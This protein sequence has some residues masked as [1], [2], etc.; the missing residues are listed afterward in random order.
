VTIALLVSVGTVFAF[1]SLPSSFYGIVKYNGENL[2]E[3]TLVEAM[4][5]NEV[6]AK[7]YSEMYQGDSVYTLDVRGDDTDTTE[8]DGGKE[9]DTIYFRVGGLM[10]SQTAEWHAGTNV[11]LDLTVDSTSALNSPQSTPTA[12]ATQTP[13]G[14]I[15]ETGGKA[16]SSNA[17]IRNRRV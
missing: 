15:E 12:L 9:G 4:V 3:G 5:N 17:I 6:C 14:F 11:S 2:P 10:A 1:P 7:G 8:Q 13:I 16:S